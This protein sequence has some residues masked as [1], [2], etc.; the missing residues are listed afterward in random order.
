MTTPQN[1]LSFYALSNVTGNFGDGG[2]FYGNNGHRGMDFGA[3]SRQAIPALRSGTVRR[4][5]YSR[6]VGHNVSIESASGDWSGYCHLINIQVSAGQ[7]VQ[8]GQIIG[9]AAGWNDDHG[10]S[11]SGV[12]LHMTRGT[13][14]E[15]VYGESVSDPRPL[16]VAILGGADGGSAGGGSAGGGVTVTIEE[17]KLLQRAAQ[18]GGY[19]GVVDGIPGINTWIG[20][21]NVLASKGFYSGPVDGDPGENTWKGVQRLA[22]LG[23]YQGPVDGYP[24]PNTYAGLATW[25]EASGDPAPPAGISGV[26]GVD[27][28]TT[29]RNLDFQALRSAGYQFA[30]VKA[31][32]SN[33]SPI[34]VAPYYTAQVTRARAAGLVI[35]HY[36]VAGSST[37]INDA[38]YFVDHLFDYRPGDLL[39]LDNEAVDNSIFWNDG[40]TAAFMQTVKDRLGKAPFFYTYSSLLTSM[41]WT[42]T[43]AVGSKLWVSHFTEI[44]GNPSIGTSFPTW[45]IHQYTESGSQNGVDLDLNVAKLSAFSGYTQPP[46]GVTAPPIAAIPGGSTGGNP[47]SFTPTVSEGITLQKLAQRGGYGGP[48]DGDPGTNSWIGIQSALRALGYYDGPVDGDPGTNTYRGLQLLAK[49]NDYYGP[50]DGVPGANTIAAVQRYL[51]STEGGTISF[52]VA[53]GMLIQRLG[54]AGGYLGTVDGALGVNSWKGAQQA[55]AGFGYVGPVDGVMGTNSWAALQRLAA[56]GGY[57]GVIDGVMG[58]NSWKGVQT[59]LQGFGYSGPIDGAPGTN[60]YAALQRVARLG[61]YVGPSDGVMGTNSWAGLQ[62]FLNGST[63]TGPIDG[64][65]GTNTYRALQSLASRG[66]YGG[67]ID[68]IPGAN[69]FAGLGNLLP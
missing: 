29:Q 1:V 11:W 67:P 47:G 61:G 13:N 32:G 35:G 63:Y 28:A 42:Q 15:C 45:D 4:T 31:G 8:Q 40:M 44:P 16:V 25:L 7:T 10:S 60:S 55:L 5:D 41:E 19:S 6:Y 48:L 17:G 36:W 46:L 2:D 37:P 24:G 59:I 9:Y 33:V 22:Q 20:V 49:A 68:G 43:K 52:S 38:N 64:A 26:Y 65:P 34:Y 27:V 53:Q 62:T 39:L 54:R 69:T 50:V 21:Q 18:L 3:S 57:A 30:F 23:G 14:V 56:K 58:T 12:H 66:G 51:D